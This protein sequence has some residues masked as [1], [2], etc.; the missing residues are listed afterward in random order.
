MNPRAIFITTMNILIL[1]VSEKFSI[2]CYKSGNNVQVT[3][4]NQS[5]IPVW[6]CITKGIFRH[7]RYCCIGIKY[8]TVS[9][10]CSC[11][12]GSQVQPPTHIPLWSS[13]LNSENLFCIKVINEYISFE[14]SQENKSS[15]VL[16]N[17]KIQNEIL[18]D[19]HSILLSRVILTLIV[20]PPEK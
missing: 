13:H 14:I 3:K 17:E 1:K 18:N 4:Q 9:L 15:Q 11:S 6:I 5:K 19:L 10:V 20:Y 7:W 2:I 8:E 16:V 12:E